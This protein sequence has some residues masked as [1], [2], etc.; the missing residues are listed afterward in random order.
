MTWYH[1][2]ILSSPEFDF[3]CTINSYRLLSTTLQ[4][5]LCL[6]SAAQRRDLTAR[7]EHLQVTRYSSCIEL[8]E[9]VSCWPCQQLIFRIFFPSSSFYT[10]W[11]C[12]MYDQFKNNNR[13]CWYERSHVRA[14]LSSRKHCISWSM[15]LGTLVRSSISAA[16]FNFPFA[17][18]ST[19]RNLI[20]TSMPDWQG[21]RSLLVLYR[22]L[23]EHRI[24]TDLHLFLRIHVIPNAER[25]QTHARSEHRHLQSLLPPRLQRHPRSPLPLQISSI[26]NSLGFL[27]L[28]RI[29]C[30]SAST[31]HA[32]KDWRGR[33]NHNALFV[34]TGHISGS[35]HP[36]LDL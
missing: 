2:F 28:A 7:H 20:S 9:M 5:H 26:W 16:A 3:D 4:N 18:K 8:V 34:R 33:N 32:S 19:L 36:E 6:T 1:S 35:L 31:V 30:N 13:P 17:S 24:Q 25:L 11:K 15:L 12:H 10:K 23:V 22:F 29:C 27:D 21:N 14:Y